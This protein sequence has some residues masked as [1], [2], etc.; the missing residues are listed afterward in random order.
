[1]NEKGLAS[2]PPIRIVIRSRR[3]KLFGNPFDSLA[4]SIAATFLSLG[5]MT[6]STN[7]RV[8]SRPLGSLSILA[9]RFSAGDLDPSRLDSSSHC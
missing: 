9:K 3:L 8:Q 1:M 2:K 6:R 7:F 5:R 4:N